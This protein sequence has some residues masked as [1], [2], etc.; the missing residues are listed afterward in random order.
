MEEKICY[1]KTIVSLVFSLITTTLVIYVGI[2]GIL[3]FS[4]FVIGWIL[5]LIALPVVKFLE[6]HLKIVRKIGSAL[7]II[8]VL[9]GIIVAFYFAGVHVW[10][11][12]R[13]AVTQFPAYY[14]S[15]MRDI[16][17]AEKQLIEI[18]DVLP[19]DIEAVFT[20]TSDNFESYM[21]Q[22]IEAISKPTVSAA[23]NLAKEIP[24][25]LIAIII[26][27]IAAYFFISD[28]EHVI[29]WSKKVTP[30]PLVER[31][32]LVVYH[33]KYAVGGYFK[34]Q[35][36]IMGVVFL[37]LFISLSIIKVDYAILIALLIAFLDFFPF[38]GTGTALIPWA[39]FHLL[40]GNYSRA[41]I[42][43]G[44]YI[45]TQAVRQ[46]I[47][48]KL[49]ADSMG[50]NPLVTLVLLYTGYKFGSV[51]GMIVAVPIGLIVINLYK[52]GAFDYILDDVKILINGVLSLRREG[53]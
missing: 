24:S 53:K 16:G 42:L 20:F 22:M 50:L 28:R 21:A 26:T 32:E 1:W 51:L 2:Q 11:L 3:F 4:P 41:A 27:I 7:T 18:L 40:I 45:S 12:T 49:V 43:I 6:K 8:I 15:L 31:M 37:M 10:D 38:F 44:I 5:A 13:D 48:P 47:Q 14:E 52:A 34:A 23:G 33:L 39:V 17:N 30:K 46:F 9:V 29:A 25:I 35:F 19:F 36:K